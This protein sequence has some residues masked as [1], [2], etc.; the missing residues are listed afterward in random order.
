[1]V[2]REIWGYFKGPE[3]AH[4]FTAIP[5]PSKARD[6]SVINYARNKLRS[7]Y[8]GSKIMIFLVITRFLNIEAEKQRY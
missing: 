8:R 2:P 3:N 1:V 7:I 4:T 6:S 5:H